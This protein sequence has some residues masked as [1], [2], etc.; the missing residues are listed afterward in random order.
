MTRREF[1]N[2][3]ALVAYAE[4]SDLAYEYE[5]TPAFA[6][7]QRLLSPEQYE[8]VEVRT[9]RGVSLSIVSSSRP[10]ARSWTAMSYWRLNS[11]RSVH[12]RSI[13]LREAMPGSLAILFSG[14]PA[15]MRSHTSF[16]TAE[17]KIRYARSS[18][19]LRHVL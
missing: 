12:Q 15:A 7:R 19:S 14:S 16:P 5:C 3:K 17:L 9:S 6:K 11:G 2:Q 13:V 4:Q 10:S 1:A 18:R 8:I